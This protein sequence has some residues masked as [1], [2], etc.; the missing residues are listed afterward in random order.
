M[1]AALAVG[2]FT[3]S[4]QADVI[5]SSEDFEGQAVGDLPTTAN[6]TDYVKTS[7]SGNTVKVIDNLAGGPT[8]Q[9]VSIGGNPDKHMTL[10]SPMSLDSDEVTSLQISL[11]VRFNEATYTEYIM[12]TEVFY[13]ALGDFSDKVS[14]AL[15]GPELVD[16]G[17]LP[18]LEMDTWYQ[19]QVITIN[20]SDPGITFTDTAKIRFA[21]G[22][23]TSGFNHNVY[24]DDIV[25]TGVVPEP[26]SLALLGLGGLLIARR[27]RA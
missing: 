3:A 15:F 25:I 6:G 13:S 18:T 1:A 24:Y 23:E 26:S 9:H 8:G 27:R 4:A 19:N 17:D 10:A 16:G 20:E 5:Y 14:V 22:P 12:S 21:K 7:N 2:V 11:A